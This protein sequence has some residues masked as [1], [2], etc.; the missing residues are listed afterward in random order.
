VHLGDSVRTIRTRSFGDCHA[1]KSFHIGIAV[2][3]IQTEAF[4]HCTKLAAV[5]AKHQDMP[6]PARVVVLG[7]LRLLI[8]LFA[9]SLCLR[10][11]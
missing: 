6:I 10:P 4:F 2:E 11:N 8:N 1:L 3:E 7:C 5:Y 9:L